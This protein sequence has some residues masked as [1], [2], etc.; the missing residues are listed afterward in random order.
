MNIIFD[1]ISLV[2]KLEARCFQLIDCQQDTPH[3]TSLGASTITRDLFMEMLE[4]LVRE[5]TFVGSWKDL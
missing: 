4:K 1:F 2:K 3:L 5:E